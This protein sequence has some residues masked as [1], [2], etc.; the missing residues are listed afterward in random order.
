MCSTLYYRSILCAVFQLCL[1]YKSQTKAKISCAAKTFP[2]FSL[3][4]NV[5]CS[6]CSHIPMLP[7]LQDAQVNGFIL[8]RIAG[9]LVDFLPNH[10]VVIP[11]SLLCFLNKRKPK[12]AT[13]DLVASG[14]TNSTHDPRATACSPARSYK[15]LVC[16][17]IVPT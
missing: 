3:R 12:E 10:V 7:L 1:E 17:I 11:L 15:Q 2:H 16:S 8:E 9:L 13:S 14:H 5:V 4:S 6:S